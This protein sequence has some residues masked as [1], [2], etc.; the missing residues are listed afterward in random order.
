MVARLLNHFS[1]HV[2]AR[3]GDISAVESSSV[4]PQSTDANLTSA[5]RE[6]DPA[7]RSVPCLRAYHTD[8]R[9]AVVSGCSAK[10]FE[11]S[12]DE[13][14]IEQKLR[15]EKYSVRIDQAD[16]QRVKPVEAYS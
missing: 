3:T 5:Q 8:D 6:N 15:R 9:P 13:V 14:A 12:G 1:Q 4:S 16:K 11:P 7:Y 2:N 10:E